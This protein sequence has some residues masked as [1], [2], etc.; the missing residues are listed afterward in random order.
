MSSAVRRMIHFEGTFKGIFSEGASHSNLSLYQF[1]E[2]S[3]DFLNI[4]IERRLQVRNITEE[5]TIDFWYA[6][7]VYA[8]RK[9]NPFPS[10]Q[11]EIILNLPENKG[12]YHADLYDV[13]I[14]GFT[15]NRL[16][17]SYPVRSVGPGR[18]IAAGSWETSGK[19]RFSIPDPTPPQPTAVQ[20]A[21]DRTESWKATPERTVVTPAVPD[22]TAQTTTTPNMI[23]LPD[24]TPVTVVTP[25][26]QPS[27]SGCLGKSLILAL[28]VGLLFYQP[29]IGI[30]IIASQLTRMDWG[31]ATVAKGRS[32]ISF[33]NIL[34][35]GITGFCLYALWG[36]G[37]FVFFILL[38]AGLLHLLSLFSSSGNWRVISGLVLMLT[39]IGLSYLLLG[40]IKNLLPDPG[41][42]RSSVRIRDRKPLPS[43][44]P[45]KIDS[46]YEHYMTWTD[47]EP[48]DYEGLYPT[49]LLEYRQSN[50][51]HQALRSMEVPG[52][53]D[54]YWR[55]EYGLL[56]RNDRKKLDSL[57]EVFK[58]RK[59]ENR[60]S[61]VQAAE[62]VVSYIQQIPYV[63]VHD[64]SCEA[65]IAQ[66]N[67]FMRSYHLEGRPCL[68]D[69]QA[70]VQSP[71]EF[72]HDLKGDCDTRS[73]FAFHILSA[74]EIPCSVWVSGV[75]GHS[76][77]G[78][79]LP[80][81]GRN[82]KNVNGTRH[83]GT[84]LTNTGF[85]LGM[86]APDQTDMDNWKV[87]LETNF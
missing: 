56:V 74:M 82:F 33:W 54:A 35:L 28:G 23:S 30:F 41:K 81:G 5:K 46:L 45:G 16:R 12:R 57:T 21:I 29:W 27:K 13:V 80:A 19:I 24:P 55:S 49:T 40:N 79:G 44:K 37:S 1:N 6:K 78:I 8:T 15:G 2:V 20:T 65:A 69:I 14:T 11:T 63:L 4:T 86:L 32:A 17:E 77:I 68:A 22:G 51:F 47:F 36:S 72:A 71:Y 66:G 73:L 25:A 87:A 58:T 3:W 64:N 60:L 48:R 76:V 9:F 53:E 43:P 31:G 26:T 70:G 84:E 7:K 18:S 42:K 50:N 52:G 59:Q 39:L 67:D 10:P 38:F 34:L 61:P 85:R 83:F 62:M 75:Y